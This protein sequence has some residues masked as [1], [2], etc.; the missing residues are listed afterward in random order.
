MLIKYLKNIINLSF[1]A[2]K[3][4]PISSI[5]FSYGIREGLISEDINTSSI[6]SKY[7]TYYN[8]KLPI[9]ILP[10]QYGKILTKLD[11]IYFISCSNNATIILEQNK[12]KTINTIKY[13]KNDKVLFNW[14]DEI[15]DN[16]NRFVRK[17]G[18][19]ILYY[20]NGE[21]YLYTIVKKTKA[22]NKKKLP[23]NVKQ[24]RKIVTM[25]LETILVNNIHT[26]YLLS[27]FDGKISKSYFIKNLI[28]KDLEDNIFQMIKNA[29]KDLNIKKYNNYNIYLHNFSRFDAYFLIKHLCK[30]GFVDPIIHKGKIISCNFTSHEN[31]ISITF[32]D[33][34]LI[35]PSSLKNLCKSFLVKDPKGIFPYKLYDINYNSKLVPD[36]KYFTG[37][38]IDEY[39]TYKDSFIDKIWNFKDESIK[40]CILDCIS[41]YQILTKFNTLIFNKFKLNINKYPTLP[42]LSF[43]LFRTHYLKED[44]IHMI[45]GK[46]GE[47]IRKGY[48]GGAVD[49]YKPYSNKKI[50]GYDVNGLYAYVMANFKYPIGNPMYFE[51]D[52]TKIEPNA[53]GFFYCKITAPN[54]LLY[55]ILQT[56]HKGNNGQL[57]TIAPLGT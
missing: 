2:Y 15:L 53:F 12:D 45:S 38:T 10:E 1:E 54:G 3:D 11:N 19:S 25:D 5:I 4:I 16:N 29:I 47:D 28:E 20:E 57:R 14:T 55:P 27:W 32:M 46:I 48:T 31:G 49:M 13:I 50:Y 34:Y 23:K 17:I 51:G 39:N 21:L 52:I 43:N 18:K 30:L 56:H 26:P 9:A 35:L 42:S 37:I 8:N 41:L 22:I 40:Y 24:N 6:T 36:F 7:H 33:S 44:T